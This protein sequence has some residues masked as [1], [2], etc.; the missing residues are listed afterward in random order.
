MQNRSFQ[1]TLWGIFFLF[2]AIAALNLDFFMSDFL[3]LLFTVGLAYLTFTF[4]RAKNWV[5]GALSAIFTYYSLQ[6]LSRTFFL[7]PPYFRNRH[8]LPDFDFITLIVF[9]FFLHLG[10][11]K[12]F[13]NKEKEK[14]V[15]LHTETRQTE[16]THEKVTSEAG[17][18]VSKEERKNHNT[19]IYFESEDR[20]IKIHTL[21]GE[22]IRYV[23]SKKIEKLDTQTL[24]GQTTV[25][26]QTKDPDAKKIFATVN[27]I[28]GE[29][30]IYV[31]YGWKVSSET[32]VILGDNSGG[33]LQN[34]QNSS[35]Y[36]LH[37]DG[38]VFLGSFS[39]R[40]F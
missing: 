30:I 24:L 12:L 10:I 27:C 17:E 38:L 6:N 36:H 16:P 26:F 23:H 40:Y 9:F 31:P 1:N 39:V 2:L 33:V 14:Y 15:F 5:L 22:N 4:Y 21:L 7:L 37:I 29:T 32:H 11:Q 28:L 35:D 20:E 34:S 13:F 19:D 18:A 8:F 3:P 25:Y